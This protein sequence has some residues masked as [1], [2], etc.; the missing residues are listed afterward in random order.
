MRHLRGYEGTRGRRKR[1]SPTRMYC[2]I[3]GERRI[4]RMRTHSFCV[5]ADARPLSERVGS[6]P[7][8]AVVCL[9]SHIWLANDA[10]M[11]K[12]TNSSARASPRNSDSFMH[13]KP[14]KV[15]Q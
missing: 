8:L 3:A 11:T 15:H 4:S 10:G 5:T 13:T 14:A 12:W 6:R 7:F 2:E 1:H 9:Q